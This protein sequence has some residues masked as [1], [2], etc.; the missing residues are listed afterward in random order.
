M[1]THPATHPPNYFPPCTQP[2][3]QSSSHLSVNPNPRPHARLPSSHRFTPSTLTKLHTHP[4]PPLTSL[5]PSNHP[6]TTSPSTHQ[7]TLRAAVLFALQV[8]AGTNVALASP[9]D[10]LRHNWTGR[11]AL[12]VVQNEEIC[13]YSDGQTQVPISCQNHTTNIPKSSDKKACQN[14]LITFYNQSNNMP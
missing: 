6:G 10:A 13:R 2:L 11:P 4:P 12:R 9:I 1:L 8:C 14:Y 7:L 3:I 5:A